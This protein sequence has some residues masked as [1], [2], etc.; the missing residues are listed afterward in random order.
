[1]VTV[2]LPR[3]LAETVAHAAPALRA[4]AD[5]LP[6]LI[7]DLAL[8]WSLDVGRPFQPGGTVSW[9]AP[10][11]TAA[12]DH[13]VIKLG[14]PHD[15]ARDEADGLRAWDGAG[16]V[17]LVNATTVGETTALLLEACRPGTALSGH[18]SPAEQ[19]AVVAGLL[20][21][22][23]IDPPAGHPFRTLASMCYWWADEF[24]AKYAAADPARRLDP[25]LARN[26]IAAFRSLPDSAPCSVLLC[27]D[28]HPDN[29]LAATREPWL[30][31]DPKPYVGDPTYDPL[32]HMLNFPDRLA[33]D[34]IA[35][36]ERMAG[37]LDLDAERLRQWAFA[38]CVQESVGQPRLH[39]VVRRL[40]I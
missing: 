2:E 16:T 11:R 29:V 33:A 24:E 3:N 4:W 25:G 15:E 38:R 7:D 34:P 35:F 10:A 9:V 1:M 8:R 32:Q 20:R 30:V 6:R 28:L 37:L 12:G 21:R 27:T 14:W 31:I 18:R 5:S 36:V 17:R 23:W 26:G 40:A 13:V 19:D 39:P 22:L